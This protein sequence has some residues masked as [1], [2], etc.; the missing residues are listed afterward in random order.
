[1][2]YT[3][4]ANYS[5]NYSASPATEHNAQSTFS[6]LNR[7]SRYDVEHAFR[8]LLS[9]FRT[10]AIPGRLC[11]SEDINT[12]VHAWCVI[13]SVMM[14]ATKDFHGFDDIDAD[15]YSR[16]ETDE[17]QGNLNVAHNLHF[18]SLPIFSQLLHVSYVSENI[19][20]EVE[21]KT[22]ASDII[23]HIYRPL[24]PFNRWLLRNI[25]F[26]VKLLHQFESVSFP[27]FQIVYL[28]TKNR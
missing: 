24:S 4:N 9:L 8:V 17:D 13:Y 28:K 1:M 14:E 11:Y 7:S 12:I 22:L 21:H 10:V 19:C 18:H 25:C 5:S 23:R 27:V 20:Y 16:R 2:R 6:S 3:W 26:H 15:L